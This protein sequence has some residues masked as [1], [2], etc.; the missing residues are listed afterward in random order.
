LS[1]ITPA[2]DLNDKLAA[3]LPPADDLWSQRR[4]SRVEFWGTSAER[5]S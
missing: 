2:F 3:Q 1:G 4:I 5:C